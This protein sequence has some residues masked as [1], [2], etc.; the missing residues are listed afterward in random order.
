MGV[1]KPVV[2]P[3]TRGRI[4][5]LRYDAEPPL[6]LGKIAFKL[7]KA[8]STIQSICNHWD[9]HHHAYTLPRPGRPLKL[10][11]EAERRLI[12]AIQHEPKACFDVF[13]EIV[14]ISR[15]T[16]ARIAAKHGLKS[17]I[18]RRKPF[19]SAINMGK[20]LEWAYMWAVFD[21]RRVMF[22]D[23]SCFKIGE[24]SVQR[25]IRGVG[26]EYWPQHIQVKFRHGK[27]IHVWGAI[28]YGVKLPLVKFELAKA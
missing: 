8:K 4:I 27:A 12:R 18:A 13:G 1:I 9:K 26:E 24:G 5:A 3:V 23:K 20:R 22:T 15:S 6:S 7:G 21:W 14:H 17:R 28:M 2:T 25:V 19:L 16:A 10:D 11:E